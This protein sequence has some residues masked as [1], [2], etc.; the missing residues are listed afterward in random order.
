MPK[1]LVIVESPAKAKTIEKFLGK[2]Y[3]VVASIGHIRDLPKSKMGIDIENDFEPQY[4]NI[5]GKG[6]VIKEIKSLAKK[7]DHVYLATDP[8]REGEAIAWHLA[9]I[10]ALNEN[11]ASRIAFNE[12]TKEA[13]KSAV[14]MPRKLDIDLID[15]QQARRV[16]DRLV[17]YSISPILWRKVKKG[18]SA[19]RVQSVATKIICD[20]EKEIDKFVSKEYWNISADLKSSDGEVFNARLVQHLNKELDIESVITANEIEK[21]LHGSEYKVEN[22]EEKIKMRNPNF[23]FTTSSMQQEAS[24]KYNFSTKK[25]MIIAQQLYEGIKLPEGFVGLI[26]YMRTDSTRISDEAREQAKAFILDE[27]GEE[28]VSTSDKV[29]KTK[30]SQDAHEA[31]RP[32]SVYRTPLSLKGIL[33]NDQY[34][35]Y[36]LIW[37]RFMASQMSPAKFNNLSVQIKNGDYLF[38]SNGSQLIFEGFLKVMN[39][40]QKDK[41]LPKLAIDEILEFDKL[42]KE[43]KFTQPP[44]RFT[45]ATLV[46]E[47]EEKGIGRPSTYAPTIST[48]LSRGY[49]E[50]QKKML[51]PTE[52]G[53]IINDIMEN[54]FNKIVAVDFTA[55][56]EQRFDQIERGETPWKNIIRDFYLPFKEMISQAENDIEKVDLTEPTDIDCEVCGSKMVIKH[57]RFGKFLACSNY[58]ECKNTKPILKEIGV[59]CPKCET[60]QIVERRTKKFKVFYGCNTF[61]DCHFV[62]WDKPVDKYCPE[63]HSIL[64]EGKGKQKDYLICSNKECKYKESKGDEDVNKLTE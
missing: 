45:E 5:R 12:I 24:N 8:D 23:S 32:S 43:Q 27:Y 9:H 44:N 35:L 42:I 51:V 30:N 55:N 17:G 7:S 52:L 13:V 28:F 53:F 11:E 46:K 10:L 14:K 19:G 16:L 29:K 4:I 56:M 39:N 60:G 54:Y 34:K 6:P 2:N 18:L 21:D 57:G 31:I 59:K 37:Q 64:L 62:S 47:M 49:V 61:P 36:E 33:S 58:P 40:S 63:C 22:I 50:K 48:I 26:T 3:K 41:L 1:N 15:A 25:T 20:R 38:K